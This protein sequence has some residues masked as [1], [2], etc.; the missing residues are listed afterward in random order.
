MWPAGL[1]VLYTAL[2]MF[3]YKVQPNIKGKPKHELAEA[4]DATTHIGI[5]SLLLF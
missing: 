1:P 4:R 3:F 2:Y 5:A